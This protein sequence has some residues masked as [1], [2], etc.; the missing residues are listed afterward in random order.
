MEK[1]LNT[2]SNKRVAHSQGYSIKNKITIIGT[3]EQGEQVVGNTITKI[4][5]ALVINSITPDNKLYTDVQ[6]D[7]NEIKSFKS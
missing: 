2:L 3:M 6:R 4:M 5:W 7:Y 1:K